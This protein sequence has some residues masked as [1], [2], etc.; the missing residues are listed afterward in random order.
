MST[1]TVVTLVVGVLTLISTVYYGM[2]NKAAVERNERAAVQVQF[3]SAVEQ[4]LDLLGPVAQVQNSVE[5]SIALMSAAL[6][7]PNTSDAAR[8]CIEKLQPLAASELE[9]AKSFRAE[10]NEQISAAGS[11]PPDGLTVAEIAATMRQREALL[12]R[13]EHEYAAYSPNRIDECRGLG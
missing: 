4:A 6:R 8:S 7:V 12:R 3:N 10:L 13:L 9:A 5:R 1:W 2:T 11:P